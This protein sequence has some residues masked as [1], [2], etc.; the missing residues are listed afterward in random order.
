MSKKCLLGLILAVSLLPFVG[1]LAQAQEEEAKAPWQSPIQTV[2]VTLPS[3]ALDPTIMRIAN[4]M[5]YALVIIAF[6]MVV[7]GGVVMATAGGDP[8]KIDFAR[9]LIM[10]AL[11]AIA[12][13]AIAWGLVS[14]VYGY[15]SK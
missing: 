15:L 14:M 11:V 6:I 3:R 5:F 10:W 13:G 8:G 4:I 12:V 1:V 7:W 9:H 2:P